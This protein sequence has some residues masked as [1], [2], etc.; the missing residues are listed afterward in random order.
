MKLRELI[1]CDLDID[2]TGIVDDSR[3]VKPGYIFVATKGFN[4]D[5]YDHI[6]DAIDNGCVF[7]VV[8]REIDFPFP[9]IIVDNID[10]YYKNICLKFYDINL[11][12]FSFIGI[13]G[14]DGKTTTATIISR[15]IKN[16]AYIGT[17]GLTINGKTI[18]TSNTTPCIS[19]LYSD[20]R[21]IKDAGIKT[22]VM[23]VSSEALLHNRVDNIKFDIVGFTNIT[24]DHLN[25]H[26]SFE[27]YVKCKMKLLDLIK[28]DS[29]VVINGDDVNLQ[30]I[31]CQ[32]MYS[33]GKNNVNFTIKNISYIN[34]SVLIELKY[35]DM[36]YSITSNLKGEYNVYNVVMAF[37]ISLLYGVDSKELISNIKKLKPISGRCEELDFGQDYTIILDYAHTINGIENILNTFKDYDR[38]ST[39]TGCAG[40]RETS[41]RPIIGK[42]VIEKSDI[43]IFT[44]DDPRYESVDTIIDEMVGDNLDYI[45]ITDR[46][47]AI[48]YAL[49]IACKRDVVLILGKGRDNYMAIGDKKVK[50]NDYEV[51]K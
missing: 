39:V 3:L 19:E 12:D 50:Y 26:G 29:Y 32:N 13:T 45:R 27:N 51:I 28:D 21:K 42:M 33:F 37:I 9:H 10:E 22:V 40:G 14:T 47:E 30:R 24:G 48:N 4:V 36:K 49:S 46:E 25:V 1:D 44:M 31:K 16:S 18:S 2:I 38:V 23:E 11:D 41:K 6:K 7:L 17:N 34:K 15:L 43:A 20:L 5:H 35:K 8:D